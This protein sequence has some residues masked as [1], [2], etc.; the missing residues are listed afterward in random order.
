MELDK[1]LEVQRRIFEQDLPRLIRDFSSCGNCKSGLG[2]F[3]VDVIDPEILVSE[4]SPLRVS[5]RIKALEL[6]NKTL[7]SMLAQAETTVD[8]DMIDVAI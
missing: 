3:I 1:L 7:R 5:G 2:R 8:I 4:V 6:E